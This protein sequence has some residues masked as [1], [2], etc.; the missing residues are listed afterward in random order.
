MAERNRIISPDDPAPPA[1]TFA[2]LPFPLVV[3]A[4]LPEGAQAHF[5][6][7]ANGLGLARPGARIAPGAMV[8]VI[9]SEVA[10]HIRPNLKQYDKAKPEMLRRAGLITPH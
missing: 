3:I 2:G 4:D 10:A 9:P 5:V 1:L 8:V 7:G 6:D